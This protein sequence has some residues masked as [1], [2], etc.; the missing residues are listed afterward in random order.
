MVRR[1]FS[2][3]TVLLSL[4]IA[5]LYI[6][7]TAYL[8]N[9][10][11]VTST[12][13]GSFPLSY[14]IAILRDLITGLT[15]VMTPLPLVFLIVIAIL[16]GFNLTLFTLKFLELRGHSGIKLTTGGGMLLGVITGGC[17]ACGI[18]VLSFIGFGG[19]LTVL[20]FGGL[21]FSILSV[22]LLSVSLYLL[23]RSLNAAACAV[24]PKGI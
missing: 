22:F 2:L 9:I 24:D 4:L 15:S 10:R 18:P 6:I 17:P 14:K 16:A 23:I 3:K 19:G 13:S 8:M 5:A 1:L 12:L 21:G 11:L 20:P 7:L